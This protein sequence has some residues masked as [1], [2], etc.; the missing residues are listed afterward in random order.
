MSATQPS[1]NRYAINGY[2]FWRLNTLIQSPGDIYESEQSGLAF[3]LGPES[4]V[5][6]V[7]V[8]Y[9]DDQVPT[10]INT[11]LIDPSRSFVGRL[12]AR[13][14]ARYQP[15]NRPGR[16]LIWPAD[17]YNPDYTPSAA[18]GYAGGDVV[19]RILPRLDVLQYFTDPP[20]ILPRRADREY[21][22]ESYKPATGARWIV[23]PTYGRKFGSITVTNRNASLAF[24]FR[25][26]G[27]NYAAPTALGNPTDTEVVIYSGALA[28]GA[29][30]VVKGFL[31]AGSDTN[32]AMYDAIVV[33][34]TCATGD[35]DSDRVPLR[36]YF[37]DE[38]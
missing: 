9:Y 36:A 6:K 24:T 31:G 14:D 23:L 15:A 18:V 12:D 32:A 34:I 5:S 17:N 38:P 20:G 7:A 13:N 3:A 2:Q 8:A 21:R 35:P 22:F 28:V 4:D 19:E 37:S 16:V 33:C 1:A 11:T 26:V 27:V 10:F 29:T 30:K 25:V